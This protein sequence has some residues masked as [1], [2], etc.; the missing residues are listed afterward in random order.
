MEGQGKERG[1]AACRTLIWKSS[2]GER[3]AREMLESLAREADTGSSVVSAL[4]ELTRKGNTQSAF[5]AAT[6]L[7]DLDLAEPTTIP[8]I[9]KGLGDWDLRK[10]AGEIIERLWGHSS[11]GPAVRYALRKETWGGDSGSASRAALLLMDHGVDADAGI[12]RGLA[13]GVGGEWGRRADALRRLRHVLEDPATRG[14][15]IETLRVELHGEHPGD[16]SAVATLLV[17]AGADLDASLLREMSG[18][19][20]EHWPEATLA[21]LALS[22]RA[23]EAREAA[24]RQG[25]PTLVRL[26]GDR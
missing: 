15:A 21:A 1:A 10:R 22:G 26:L 25:F 11:L 8:P 5:E 24:E 17:T 16:R 7:I 6:C 18:E 2:S 14:L 4:A 23:A 12:V 13:T 19:H 20:S 9:V 3:S